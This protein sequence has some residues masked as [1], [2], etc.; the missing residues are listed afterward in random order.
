[1]NNTQLRA[2]PES[3]SCCASAERHWAMAVTNRARPVERPATHA[4]DAALVRSD[5]LIWV[6]RL[7]A[8]L[9]CI[10]A[11]VNMRV[12]RRMLTTGRTISGS[13]S[14]QAETSAYVLFV[15]GFVH[16]DP[17]ARTPDLEVIVQ[18]DS[19]CGWRS[20]MPYLVAV[21]DGKLAIRGI[22]GP[23]AFASFVCEPWLRTL[24]FGGR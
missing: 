1:M 7:E 2:N 11:A 10:A 23:E 3:P 6:A 5:G 21:H 19:R 4:Q 12:G 24:A 13:V 17:E 8:E 9:E 16:D 18:P 22:G 20:R 14:L 15:F